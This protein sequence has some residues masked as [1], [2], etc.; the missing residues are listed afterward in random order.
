MIPI[1]TDTPVR[2]TPWAN[3][4][5]LTANILVAAAVLGGWRSGN[6]EI[7]RLVLRF[8]Q[9]GRFDGDAPRLYQFFTYQFLHANFA[10]IAGN[11]LFLYVFGNPVNARMGHVPYLLFYLAGGVFAASGYALRHDNAMVGASGAIAAVTTAY[12]ALFP[13]SRITILYWWFIIGTFE[14]PSWFMIVLKMIV[15]DNILAPSWVHDGGS[16]VA[17]DAHLAG[18]AFGFVVVAVLLALRC[19]P[20]GQFDVVALW[21]RWLRRRGLV[22]LPTGGMSGAEGVPDGP[23]EPDSAGPRVIRDPRVERISAL[24]LRIAEALGQ[25][26]RDAA[27]RLYEELIEIDPRQILARGQQLEVANR[28]CALNRLPQAV[29]AYEAF[30]AHYGPSP[31]A[32]HVELLLGIIYARDLQQHEIAEHHLRRAAGRIVDEKR[33]EQCQYWLEVCRQ[34]RQRRRGA[35]DEQP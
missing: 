32:E 4:V 25:S 18:Y 3:Y 22:V 33:A 20:R 30:L 11:M 31:E 2:R 34:A 17:F 26:D 5:L 8:Q 27:A 12:L 13:R 1:S 6:P 28:L 24:R 16:N 19:L 35:R 21:H 7:A 14:L 10:H 15:W 23:G 9:W 29:L